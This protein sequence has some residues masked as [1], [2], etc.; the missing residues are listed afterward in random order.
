MRKGAENEQRELR[1]QNEADGPVFKIWNDP[2][3]TRVGRWLSHR[4]LDELPQLINVIRGEMV[5]VGPRPLPVEEAKKVPRRYFRR[6]E[7]LPGLTSSWVVNGAHN[8]SFQEWMKYDLEDVSEQGVRR[9][10]RIM[11]KTIWMM[12]EGLIKRGENAKI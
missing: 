2:R 8:L 11:G 12:G 6:Y 10:L 4:G 7:V 5:F 9:D 3:H 1:H